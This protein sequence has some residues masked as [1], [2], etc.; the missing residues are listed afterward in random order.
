MSRIA[1][2]LIVSEMVGYG[3]SL[4]LGYPYDTG[5]A[6]VI[7]GAVVAGTWAVDSVVGYFRGS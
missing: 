4:N 2:T 5:T 6:A 7:A 1:K 3:L